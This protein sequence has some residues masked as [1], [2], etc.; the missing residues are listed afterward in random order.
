MGRHYGDSFAATADEV[1]CEPFRPKTTTVNGSRPTPG[2]DV[3]RQ[4]QDD[5]KWCGSAPLYLPEGHAAARNFCG[6]AVEHR[7]AGVVSFAGMSFTSGE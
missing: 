3:V 7:R 2:W 1:R 4:R 6:T 5:L